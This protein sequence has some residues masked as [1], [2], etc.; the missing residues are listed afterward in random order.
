MWQCIVDFSFKIH[1]RFDCAHLISARVTSNIVYVWEMT[2]SYIPIP[3]VLRIQFY[4]VV[5]NRKLKLSICNSI[6]HVSNGKLYNYQ[7]ENFS[8]R[9]C[10]K[11]KKYDELVFWRFRRIRWFMYEVR[12][13]HIVYTMGQLVLWEKNNR[14]E[15]RKLPHSLLLVSNLQNNW[16][17]KSKLNTEKKTKTND[18]LVILDIC[19]LLCRRS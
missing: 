2:H 18:D 6:F 19:L 13:I 14:I 17:K 15:F 10:R 16:T 8:R 1:V 3:I 11:E 7:H 5:S 4:H 12:A 9:T